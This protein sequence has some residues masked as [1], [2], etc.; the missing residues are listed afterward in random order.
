[1]WVLG[2]AGSH[3]SAAAL[4]RDGSVVADEQTERLTR[5]K[6]HP[7][8]LSRMSHETVQVIKYC[9][10]YAG[11]DLPD[12]DVIATCSPY[13]A[14][15]GFAVQ[16]PSTSPAGLPRSSRFPITSRTRNTPSTTPPRPRRSSSSATAAGHRK[17]SA[18]GWTSPNARR[19]RSGMSPRPERSRSRRMPT[20]D[21]NSG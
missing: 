7:I 19:I 14:E 4:I 20:T 13:E 21:T 10:D 17:T 18:P 5:I 1:M 3:N 9:L 16:D 11:I 2:I 12:V 8:Q 15:A 6:R